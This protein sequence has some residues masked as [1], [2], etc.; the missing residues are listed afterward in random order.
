MQWLWRLFF[1]GR[2]RRLKRIQL[3]AAHLA[4]G[5]VLAADQ[6]LASARPTAWSQDLAVYHY[7]L[8]KVRLE[9]GALDQAEQHLHAA[10]CLG[11]DLPSVRFSL[12]VVEVR[13][14]Q[15]ERA[16]ALLQDLESSDDPSLHEQTRLMRQVIEKNR[17]GNAGPEVLSAIARFRKKHLP[18]VESSPG[19]TLCSLVR[20]LRA[21]QLSAK[22]RDDGSL[23]LGEL[24]VSQCDGRWVFGLESQDHRVVVRGYLHSPHRLLSSFLSGEQDSLVLPEPLPTLERRDLIPA[25]SPAE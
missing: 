16:L 2:L 23:L 5:D 10:M 18:Q 9:Q 12:A 22:D 17:D 21:R 19:E 8:G 7:V 3:A 20:T 25:D 4:R 15:L 13:R 1:W 14:C 11:L 24:L 6:A